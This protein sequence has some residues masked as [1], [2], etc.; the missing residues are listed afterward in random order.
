MSELAVHSANAAQAD[1]W[2]GAAGERWRDQQDHQDAVLQPVS[3]RL[4]AAADPKPGQK[5]IDVG[6]GCGATTF[7]FALRVAPDGE[8]LG[9]DLSEV[10]LARARD[11]AAPG[12]PARFIAAD[13]TVHTMPAGWADLL[14][15]RFG[16][17]F[18]ADPALSF[19]NL[20]RGLRPGG[21]VVFACWREPKQNPWVMIPLQEAAKHVPPLP[22]TNPDDPGPFAFANE[23][24]VRR[25]LGD[26][27]FGDVTLT[28]HD[29]ELD[30]AI[31]RGV[32]VAVA[33]ALA[34]G[35]AS[36]ALTGQSETVRAA[37]AADIRA[38]LA[39]R[40]VGDSVPLG[41]AIWIVSATNPGK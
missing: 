34:I 11:R 9:L 23:A 3:G 14:V 5:V 24:R 22:E 20:R 28:P 39:A 38:A 32:D 40:A 25:V 2:N 41:A 6:C 19:A 18:F 1:Y 26:A 8:A 17:M 29:L 35:P 21:R 27:G 13:A 30:I 16:V 37:A 4:V 36:R 33:A 15:S 7:E 10:M 31:G 12:L